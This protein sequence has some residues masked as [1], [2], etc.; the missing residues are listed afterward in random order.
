MHALHAGL[1]RSPTARHDLTPVA[2]AALPA[3]PHPRT[4][5]A[6]CHADEACLSALYALGR[7]TGRSHRLVW[8]AACC[9]A[10]ARRGGRAGVGPAARRPFIRSL[11][12]RW[13]QGA[14]GKPPRPW[15]GD[16]TLAILS[17]A[18]GRRCP[19]RVPA[20]TAVAARNGSLHHVT[21]GG[22]R[23]WS[24]HRAAAPSA[25]TAPPASTTSCRAPR[26][27]GLRVGHAPPRSPAVGNIGRSPRCNLHA[28]PPPVHAGPSSVTPR[29]PRHRV[30]VAGRAHTS[31]S[32]SWASASSSAVSGARAPAHACAIACTRAYP[33]RAPAL[34]GRER[35][36]GRRR[37]VADW[38]LSR[39]ARASCPLCSRF[40]ACRPAGTFRRRARRSADFALGLHAERGASGCAWPRAAPTACNFAELG[41]V[42][43]ASACGECVRAS[44][45]QGSSCPG[46]VTIFLLTLIHICIIRNDN[47]THARAHLRSAGI[48]G[49]RRLAL[50]WHAD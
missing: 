30:Q 4:V 23:R 32:R 19:R 15:R 12:L 11:A 47:R 10:I 17:A 42:E 28:H 22:F 49:I 39:C 1:A 48:S 2:A 8:R 18:G 13:S 44:P 50:S 45:R 26:I 46:L 35:S 27:I 33:L 7:S 40:S 25:W 21:G 38:S 37:R 14:Q 31:S 9:A 36:S 20:R 5:A 16:F 43:S 29:N 41:G 24:S 34:D 6:R 3:A